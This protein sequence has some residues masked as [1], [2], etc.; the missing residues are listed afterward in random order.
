MQGAL[1][2]R[3]CRPSKFLPSPAP[4]A[5][6]SCTGGDCALTSARPKAS[7]VQDNNKDGAILEGLTDWETRFRP[8]CRIR[9][10]QALSGSTTDHCCRFRT[11]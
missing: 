2:G 1:D 6:A 4:C 10:G 3:D 5:A 8:L 9:T 11:C 7:P